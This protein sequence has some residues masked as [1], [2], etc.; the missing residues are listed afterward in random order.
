MTRIVKWTNVYLLDKVFGR[1][2]KWEGRTY[3]IRNVN[4]EETEGMIRISPE[5]SNRM[6]LLCK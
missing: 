5:K 4:N 1:G 2:I 3:G 6:S